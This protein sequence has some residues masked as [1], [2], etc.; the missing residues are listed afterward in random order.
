[1]D[2]KHGRRHP[3]PLEAQIVQQ[4]PDQK[5]I[6][7]VQKE[8]HQ[9]VTQGIEPPGLIIQ[10]KGGE[11]QRVVLLRGFEVGPDGPEALPVLQ[12]MVFHYIISIVNQPG[13]IQAGPVHHQQQ[14]QDNHPA[15]QGAPFAGKYLF[16]SMG[17]IHLGSNATGGP[18]G[19]P[20]PDYN[21]SSVRSQVTPI[22]RNRDPAENPGWI[23]SSPNRRKMVNQPLRSPLGDTRWKPK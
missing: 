13:A 19:Y 6:Q 5:R 18:A 16:Q 4:P 14:Q 9:V 8:V 7:Q 10:P 23:S 21:G 20:P 15:N 17:V 3:G 11:N 1:M 2:G 12:Q 22:D